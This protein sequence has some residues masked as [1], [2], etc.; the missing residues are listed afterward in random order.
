MKGKYIYV[1]GRFAEELESIKREVNIGKNSVVFDKIIEHI[2]VG[3]EMENIKNMRFK[4][5]Q[6]FKK[7]RE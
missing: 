7:Y 5:L 6:I 4:R 1:P 3:R 2:R